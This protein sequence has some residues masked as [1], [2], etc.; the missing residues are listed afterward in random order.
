MTLAIPFNNNPICPSISYNFA[1]STAIPSWIT[2][3]RGSHATYFDS[4]SNLN[5]AQNN[6][7]TNNSMAGTGSGNLPTNWSVGGL[8]GL[9]YSVIGSGTLSQGTYI[10]IRLYGTST[11][12]GT[13]FIIFQPNSTVAALNGQ[14]WILSSY[15]GLSAGSLTNI[16]D[17]YLAISMANSSGTYL[18]LVRSSTLVP[19]T[20]V[21]NYQTGNKLLNQSTIAY[22]Y[23]SLNVQIN[24]TGLAVDVTFRF[25]LPQ[26]SL[27]TAAQTTIP[28][29]PATSSSAYYAPRFDNQPAYA[30]SN[31]VLQSDDQT[32]SPWGVQTASVTKDGTLSLT[33]KQA[34]LLLDNSTNTEHY[35]QQ[36]VSGIQVAQ[37]LMYVAYFKQG[38]GRYANLELFDNSNVSNF[39]TIT[40]DLQTSG[41]STTFVSGQ[42]II[43]NYGITHVGNGWYQA[44]LS[45]QLAT[46]INTG[47]LV[48]IR[49]A[50]SLGVTG[51]AVSYAGT[52][53]GFY[54]GGIQVQPVTLVQGNTPPTYSAT[55]T[56]AVTPSFAYKSMG[57]LLE[58][59]RT[60]YI[61]NNT[62]QS[63]VLGDAQ[64]VSNSLIPGAGAGITGWTA[65]VSSAGTIAA[66]AAGGIDVTGT[67]TGY[68]GAYIPI[69]VQSGVSYTVTYTVA[70]NAINVSIGS[71]T[72][73]GVTDIAYVGTST[74]VGVTT[75][76]QWT[77]AVTGTVYV[78]V[79]RG[80][81]LTTTVTNVYV[82]KTYATNGDL[83]LTTFGTGSG[84][85]IQNG[86]KYITS[87]TSSASY[88]ANL[89]TMAGD[90]TNGAYVYMA[91]ITTTPGVGYTLQVDIGSN[92]V[93]IQFGTTD[94]GNDIISYSNV[95]PI[96]GGAFR[97]VPSTTTT[98]IRFVRIATGN[99]TIAN[100]RV[101]MCGSS[102]T[103]WS[104]F[105]STPGLCNSIVASGY[106][107]G[108]PYIRIRCFGTTS[109]INSSFTFIF[110]N[111]SSLLP[112]TISQY[113]NTSLFL[114]LNAGTIGGSSGTTA[115]PYIGV[116]EYNSSFTY[117]QSDVSI[118]LSLT[119]PVLTR[120]SGTTTTTN[121]SVA[122]T[123]YPQLYIYFPSAGTVV[124]FT[125]DIAL[126]Q[127][128]LLSAASQTASSVIPTYGAG[129]PKN[130][131][132]ATIIGAAATILAS[133]KGTVAV[134]GIYYENSIGS[135]EKIIATNGSEVIL[136]KSS[137]GAIVNQFNLTNLATGNLSN[138]TTGN[139]IAVAY[140][141][142]GRSVVGTGATLVTDSQGPTGFTAPYYLGSLNS[143]TPADG[144]YSKVA[145]WSNR[146]ADTVL[147]D[148]VK[149]N[150]PL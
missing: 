107:N 6:M 97:F 13:P 95:G 122:Y 142:A 111:S 108:I 17:L 68:T 45:T 34:V 36:V 29:M 42:T 8:V 4:N 28:D 147:S 80:T 94:G 14:S 76:L 2:H 15:L 62:A 92:N 12:S 60:N 119:S 124:D 104:A 89:I 21:S 137:T 53:T 105:N 130:A 61:R 48:R 84:G 20:T 66:N 113:V 72:T 22:I 41:T 79:W 19:T 49:T 83:A 47:I 106:N 114:A 132:I 93:I 109:V 146:L 9:S 112:A 143:A 69:T 133:T 134:E 90:G 40:Y 35:V 125:I 101:S 24:S 121:A 138:W 59:T 38:T 51:G 87:G 31:V 98:Y 82:T 67:G 58:G 135:N 57:L 26:L 117:L 78:H 77:S 64:L 7:I 46:T 71:T 149:T 70:T 63:V 145:F 37:P 25:I 116:Y 115:Y 86:W 99:A 30:S 85:A 131:D 128:E 56:S 55:T 118:R 81:A 18:N 52:G 144:W 136:S 10:D 110:D 123:A 27:V 5:Y 33:G 54:I 129:T 11:S 75:S 23:P 16:G 139:R 150:A 102:P 126:P 1:T 3:S 100:A 44:W 88:S 140:S 74:G 103:Y 39:A 32:I 73:V 148:K 65:A 127:L 141:S 96:T 120:F 91:P 50:S 43:L